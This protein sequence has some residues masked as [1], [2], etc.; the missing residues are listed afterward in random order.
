MSEVF[1]NIFSSCYEELRD[2]EYCRGV[3]ETV[4]ELAE[5]RHVEYRDE[6][7]ATRVFD[8]P[9]GDRPRVAV[10]VDH[11]RKKGLVLALAGADYIV[12]LMYER[13]DS[14]RFK[15]VYAEVTNIDDI[16][17]AA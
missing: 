12:F 4:I 5:T 10:A 16:Q 3:V 8:L 14:G 6:S 1:S 17:K 7:G 13:D 15:P 9:R 11:V 2:E